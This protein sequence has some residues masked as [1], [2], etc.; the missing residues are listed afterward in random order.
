MTP[1]WLVE[2]EIF[3]EDAEPLLESLKK[4]NVE[5]VTVKFGTSYEDYLNV[6]KPED[7]VVFYGSLQLGR[8]IQRK[9]QWIPGVYCNLP[10]FECLYYYPR[11][12]DFLFNSS[13]WMLPFGELKRKKH[14]IFCDI[15]SSYEEVFLRPSSG[16][17][18]FTGKVISIENWDNEIKLMRAD[19]EDLMVVALS[20]KIVR[21]WRLV[22][23]ENIPITG[24][25]Y[26]ENGEIVRR[27]EI[28]QN[29]RDFATTV[30]S[31]IK[32][33]PDKIWT[34]DICSNKDGH[35][36][37]LEVGSFSCAGL[38]AC[39]TDLIVQTVNRLAL[40]EYDEIN[41]KD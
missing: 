9:T 35:L 19:P 38:Y 1:R 16:F 12:G 31:T 14:K 8:F 25:Q 29:V 15:I 34:L 33:N 36:Y 22:V 10:K 27:S 3:G 24:G 30:L 37:V 13:Y 11:F 17:K 20:Q 40:E 32:Y 21:E 4:L 28:D 41:T 6:F 18:A 5:H 7:C 39:D 2:P 26:K 23:A